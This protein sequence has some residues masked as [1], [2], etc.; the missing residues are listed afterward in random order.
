MKKNHFFIMIFSLF[1]PLIL[2]WNCTDNPFFGEEKIIG[3]VKELKE[4]STKKFKGYDLHRPWIDDIKLK[5]KCGKEMRWIPDVIDC[6][7]DSGSAI[8]AQFH[9]PFENKKEF[10]KRFK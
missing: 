5:C 2:I 3:S 9:Y 1:C 10:E 7:Y 4:N 6:W 8:F